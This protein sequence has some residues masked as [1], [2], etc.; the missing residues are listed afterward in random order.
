MHITWRWLHKVTTIL[1][2]IFILL[3][4]VTGVFLAIEP[5]LIYKSTPKDNREANITL[6]SLFQKIEANFIE[7]YG[8][9]RDAYGNLKVQGIGMEDDGEEYY[10]DVHSGKVISP[11]QQIS[12]LFKFSREIHR[13]L[14]LKTPG[15]IL[16]G[17]SALGMFFL[18]LSGTFLQVKRAGSWRKVFIFKK[19]GNM[20]RDFHALFSK[21][22]Y[23]P[24]AIVALSAIILSLYRFFPPPSVALEEVSV[25]T[26]KFSDIPLKD[27]RK[28]IF[29]ID[30]S[31]ITT[32]QSDH[33]IWELDYDKNVISVKDKSEFEKLKSVSYWLHTG[34]G[35]LAWATILLLTSLVLVFLSI[36]GFK[37]LWK[38]DLYRKKLKHDEIKDNLILIGSEMGS[39][40]KFGYAFKNA[41]EKQGE[42][43]FILGMDTIPDI[44]KVKKL[45]ILTSTYGD[46]DPPVHAR[47]AKDQIIE[48]MLQNDSVS[49]CVL[50][51]GSKEYPEFCAY[52]ETLRDRISAVNKKEMVPY[53]TVDKQSV[54]EFIEWIRKVNNSLGWTLLVDTSTL[55][56]ERK[57][58]NDIFT[59]LEKKEEGDTFT[60]LLSH[61]CFIW[62]RSGDLLGVY[63]HDEN[64]ERYYSIAVIDRNKLLLVIKRTGVCSHYLGDLNQGDTFKAFIKPNPA[65]YYPTH[66]HPVV[67]IS[68][69]TGIAP[70]L[71]MM[72]HGNFHLFW[73]GRYEKDFS[74]F[75]SY[76]EN[77]KV[78]KSFSKGVKPHYV[79]DLLP[80][81]KELIIQS[82]STGGSVMI[83][84]SLT[85]LS[86]VLAELD[87]ILLDS[88][89]PGTTLLRE[90]GR[91][92]VD[93]Y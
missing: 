23:I 12:T 89:L 59:I 53:S 26:L 8:I 37:M 29:A 34:E 40:W 22:W 81:N 54:F 44:S 5:F 50:G 73:G 52:A 16:M 46:G 93:C 88:G 79:Q 45:F 74:L 86:G 2:G 21:L 33:Q 71:G 14:F 31:E 3:A 58:L 7:I 62:I 10:I 30:N 39:T 90:E 28:I 32:L 85:M 83:C 60:L 24:I 76:T 64:V 47:H 51:F 6:G 42:K 57:K 20:L 56:P 87:S 84:G 49:F 70:F 1:F 66:H 25:S 91:V 82:V 69:G 38:K 35:V 65:F 11:P 36:T 48:K 41:M 13:S 17:L 78:I 15:R 55:R 67:F 80:E 68:N 27:V 61:Q 9:E 75:S 77:K 92:L 19:P 18:L 43:V 72:N 63:P 4:S